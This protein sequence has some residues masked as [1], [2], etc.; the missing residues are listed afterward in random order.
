MKHIYFNFA[1]H[2]LQLPDKASFVRK[3]AFHPPSDPVRTVDL[4]AAQYSDMIKVPIF[5]IIINF[6]S[7]K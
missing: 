7:I 5:H 1:T 4:K 2:K 6:I 3:T